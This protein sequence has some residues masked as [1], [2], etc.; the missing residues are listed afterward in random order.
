VHRQMTLVAAAVLAFTLTACGDRDDGAAGSEDLPW[1]TCFLSADGEFAVDLGHAEDRTLIQKGDLGQ[2][3]PAGQ[4]R[5]LADLS[6][7]LAAALREPAYRDERGNCRLSLRVRGSPYAKWQ[8][9]LWLLQTAAHPA[10]RMHILDLRLEDG[11]GSVRLDLPH[12]SGIT[13]QQVELVE[14]GKEGEVAESELEGGCLVC[15]PLRIKMFRRDVWDPSTVYTRFKLGDRAFKLAAGT[16]PGQPA[17]EASMLKVERALDEALEDLGPAG[18]AAVEIIA[19]PPKGP[20]TPYGEV[21]HLLTQVRAK[22]DYR[23]LLQGNPAP[24]VNR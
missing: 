4:R 1:V 12:D 20:L 18:Q 13:S 9:V 6:A 24:I 21:H 3:D 16:K 15:E 22:G 2:E 5:A 10:V 14:E 8:Y 7:A 11:T 23:I 17:Y 19:P